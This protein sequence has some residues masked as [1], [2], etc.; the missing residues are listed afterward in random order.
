M[1]FSQIVEHL[2][3]QI[4][5]H[6]STPD[7]D[8]TGVA[9]LD[10]AQ[11]HQL[12]YV[13]NAKYIAQVTTTQAGA[14]IIPDEAAV[15]QAANDQG[16][17][18]LSTAQPRLV[19]AQ[20]IRL[21]YQPFQPEP[22]IHPTAV[23]D[24][25]VQLGQEVAIGPHVV[26]YENCQLGDRTRVLANTVIYPGVTIGADCLLHANCTIEERSQI[27]N[28]CVI[29]AGAAIG[30]E[31][32][33]FVPTA[34]GWFK[35]EQ[36]G[37]VILE[38]GV[39][40]GCNGAVDRPTVGVTKIGK[41][42]KLDNLVHI[43][44]NAQIG[45]GCAMAA[46]VGIAGSVSVGNR[47]ILAGQVGVANQAKIGDGAIASAQTG[48]H[49]EVKPGEVVSGSPAVPNKLYLKASAIYKKLPEMYQAF[50]KLQKS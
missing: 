35:I 50:K 15:K 29:H 39:E 48:I 45:E 10:A 31:G 11:S 40:V 12:S 22:G 1:Q 37:Y 4:Q 26:I 47:V 16:I 38:D 18:W 23:I 20:A 2:S 46:Q 7:C 17:A 25:S 28:G 32:F 8:I 42:T 30:A 41:N 36:S 49:G 34:E 21:F 13:E 19:F 27:G 9:A 14:L 6:S 44:H 3:A 43:A 5:D 24:P 33:G